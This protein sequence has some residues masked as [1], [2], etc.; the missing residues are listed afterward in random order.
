MRKF[1]VGMISAM[2]L[3]T[4]GVCLYAEGETEET[5]ENSKSPTQTPAAG[6]SLQDRIEDAIKNN[7]KYV[8]ED[9]DGGSIVIEK[10]QV[11]TLDLNGHTLTNTNGW[12]TIENH[13]TLTIS[14]SKG[15]GTVDNISHGHAAIYN[16]PEGTVTLNGGTYTRSKEAG[17]DAN[18]SGDNSW[19]TI[20][21]YGTMTINDGV[22]VNQ[23]A[24]GNGKYSSLIA[25]GWYD[26]SK[27]PANNEPEPINGQTAKLTINGGNLSGGLWVVKN[28]DNGE[29]IINGGT[30][31]GYASGGT[32]VNANLLTIN[33]GIL[34]SDDKNRPVVLT[35]AANDEVDKG[36]TNITGGTFSGSNECITTSNKYGKEPQIGISGGTFSNDVSKYLASGNNCAFINGK[37]EIIK[38]GDS[39]AVDTITPAVDETVLNNIKQIDDKDPTETVNALQAIVKAP[40]TPTDDEKA[41]I[42]GIVKNLIADDSK[43]IEY[44]YFDFSLYVMKNG[45]LTPNKITELTEE[46]VITLYLDD[47]TLAKI[48]G[49]D[50]KLLRVHNG[51]AEVLDAELNGNALT[52]KTSKFSTYS[53]AVIKNGVKPTEAT[54]ETKQN[55]GWDDGGPFTTDNCGNV[56]DRW[57]NKIY[58]A[59]GCS[60]GGYNLVRTGVE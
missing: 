3:V 29:T 35:I 20:K 17:S 10:N 8:L 21:N 37:Y 11:L 33:N 19:Y 55:S 27:S 51:D 49:N 53:I 22:T 14:D 2:M 41:A 12:H 36:I 25:N 38:D 6:L 60:T 44:E 31:K 28:D 24:E 57:G 32:V 50:F 1:L 52:F 40:I 15:N 48:K 16:Y 18:T 47:A 9:Y 13:G 23:G 58:E 39:L 30:I 43:T 26:I 42:E 59:N 34:I 56:F 54:T 7:R 5:N 46:A 45:E 4:S